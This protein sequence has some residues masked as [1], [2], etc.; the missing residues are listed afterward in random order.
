MRKMA[1]Y[2]PS[3][4]GLKFFSALTLGVL[5]LSRIGLRDKSIKIDYYDS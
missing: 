2:D 4:D 3:G 1:Y 5:F